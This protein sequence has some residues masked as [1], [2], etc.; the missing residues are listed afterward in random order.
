MIVVSI[1][2]ITTERTSKVI[3]VSKVE[4]AKQNIEDNYG[5]IYILK[6]S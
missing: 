1:V 6:K 5:K 2:D 4:D 3:L